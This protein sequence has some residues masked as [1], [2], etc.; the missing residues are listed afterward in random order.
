[1]KAIK[2]ILIT[3]I[4]LV[5]L[6]SCDNSNNQET[7]LEIQEEA[8]FV[9][10]VDETGAFI[11]LLIG[12]NEAIVYVC[13]GDEEIA[14]W[15]RGAIDDPEDFQL[16]NGSGATVQAGFS[17]KSF[18]GSVT[19]RNGTSR[20]FAASPNTGTLTGVFRVHGEVADKEGV[21]AGWILD[22]DGTERGAMIINGFFQDTPSLKQG[23]N[24]H[25]L[26]ESDKHKD[27][28]FLFRG[29]SFSVE[30]FF[31][32]RRGSTSIVTING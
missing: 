18:S 17:E 11:A 23:S 30:R 10:T 31:I 26:D 32:E 4:G 13:N 20:S 28:S 27:I 16:S 1:M 3:T 25:Q 9:G 22:S 19:L 6:L 8:G 24:F 7:V 29:K 14:E 15:F 5:V 2:A 12:G 21:E